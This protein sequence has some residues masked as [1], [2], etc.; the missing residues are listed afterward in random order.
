MGQAY[1]WE[2]VMSA[3]DNGL[4]STIKGAVGAIDTLD[5]AFN[6]FDGSAS[7]AS[8]GMERVAGAAGKSEG[9]LSRFKSALSFGS[10][11]GLAQQG[12]QA[13]TGGIGSIVSESA[14]AS[15]SINK[16][17]S[18]MD[19]AGFTKKQT[20]SATKD[21]KN[22]ADQTV[23]ELGDVLNTTAQ[24]AANGVPGYQKLT[25]A[26][27]N[28]NAVAGG[29]ADTFKSVAMVMTQTAGAGKLTTENWNQLTDAI[30]GASGVLQAAMK[31]NGAYTGNFRDAMANGEITANEFNKAISQTGMTKAAKE[32][33]KSTATFEGAI[34]NLQAGAVN[35]FL[36][37]YNAIGKE[38]IT[39]FINGLTSA[40]DAA[41]PYISKGIKGIVAGFQTLV[42]PIKTIGMNIKA[43]LAQAFAN[44]NAGGIGKTLQSLKS[45]FGSAFAGILGTINVFVIK[46]GEIFGKITQAFS[47]VFSFDKA[48]GSIYGLQT[49]VTTAF[50]AIQSAIGAVGDVLANLP[51]EAIFTAVKVALDGIIKVLTPIVGLVAKAF[52]SDVVRAFGEAIIGA[53]A[54]F[55][56]AQVIV[57]VVGTISR[58]VKGFTMVFTIIKNVVGVFNTLKM[59][60][61]FMSP[62]GWIV[63][64]IAAVVTGL[65]YFFAKTQ[66]GQKIW[67]AF[68]DFLKS[69]WTG[70]KE[71]AS[72]VWTAITGFITNAVT[73]TQDA[74]NGITTF[75]SNLWTGITSAASAAWTGFTAT[76]SA[77]WQ[78]IVTTATTVFTALGAFFGTIW[79]GIVTVATA[80]WNTFGTS[81]TTIWNGIVTTAKG[82]WNMLKSVIMG[83]ILIVIDLLTGDWTKLSSDLS[84]IWNSIKDAAIQIWNGLKTY[85]S[86]VLSFW[87]ALFSSVW[88]TISS[89][90]SSIWSAIISTGKSLWNGFKSFMSGLWNA[91]KSVTSAVWNGIK[92]AVSSIISGT[93]SGAKSAWNGFKSFMSALWSG[94]KSTASAAWN[95]LKST[96]ISIAHAIYNGAKAAWSGF[97]GMVRGIVNGVRGAF[98]A[99]RNINLMAAGKAIINSFFNGLISAY[100][101]VKGFISG[102]GSWIRKHKG[103]ISYD[104]RLLIPAG[105]AIMNG[106]N[107]GLVDKFSTV[108][109][110]V[111]GMADAIA[112]AATPSIST[113]GINGAINSANNQLRQ[114]VTASVQG[115]LSVS[116]RPLNVSMN[117]NGT[118]WRG[119]VADI[120]NTQDVQLQ[121]QS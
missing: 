23:Y 67:A 116:Q 90:L 112:T 36:A 12:M 65:T 57:G 19:F 51:W 9:F 102:I 1:N 101:K 83:P 6:K 11:F 34:G 93:I 27:G 87:K 20:A 32:A 70:L 104:K 94:I 45:V 61:G 97:T 109:K 78:G 108:K 105:N 2:A 16:F 8:N 110:N 10:V 42:G 79:N 100:S 29:N 111:S 86:G 21:M 52:Q 46:A 41:A 24:L 58:L 31:K 4:V 63:M 119:F 5:V 73:G 113:D 54:A 47:K 44:L 84:L 121:L 37:I 103:P 92:S 39:G 81:I 26:A 99:L 72:N 40:I 50:T 35:A 68:V 48:K 118:E 114:G 18:T 56:A 38:N 80:V 33:A 98:N 3:K 95:G 74:W 106:L 14:N 76:L 7:T 64:G 117:V 107:A 13:L 28:L 62:G 25:K 53:F 69:A 49:L 82:V 66:T 71:L 59:V 30:P 43:S 88:K 55:K 96:V 60:L 15:D 77:I 91:I 22:Y 115:Q 85:F 120:T 75:F 17:K 89:V